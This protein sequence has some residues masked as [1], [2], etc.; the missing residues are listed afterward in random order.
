[1]QGE[2]AFGALF[3]VCRLTNLMTMLEA[4]APLRELAD[5]ET[6]RRL[7]P[8]EPKIPAANSSSSL[9]SGGQQTERYLKK[10]IEIY[11]EQIFAIVS[12]YKNIFAPAPSEMDFQPATVLGLKS[13]TGVSAPKPVSLPPDPV[14][15]IP[16]ALATFPMHL[17]EMLVGTLKKYLPNVKDKSSRESL[18]TQVLYCAGSLAR[19]GG[20][21]SLIL[22]Q[23]EEDD[24][25]DE[26]E[27]S[28]GADTVSE[29]EEVMKK[30]RILAEKLDQLAA[31][32]GDSGSK[33]TSRTASSA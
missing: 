11:R 3:L 33:A 13:P 29:W 31:N 12:L 24:D 6:N 9:W 18:L 17:A 22:S 4:L 16:P 26:S 30:H 28:Q 1:M 20:D 21:F 7:H 25:D 2:G 15:S 5:Q 10:Y 14:S 32:P 8:S 23:L 27:S 19:L